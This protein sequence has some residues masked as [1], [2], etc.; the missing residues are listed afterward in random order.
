ML[1]D[2]VEGH[3]HCIVDRSAVPTVPTGTAGQVEHLRDGSPDIVWGGRVSGSRVFHEP[4][5]ITE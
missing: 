1:K 2:E 3:V 4:H 5:N